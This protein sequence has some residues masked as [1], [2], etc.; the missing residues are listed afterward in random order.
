M[1]NDPLLAGW[2]IWGGLI[3]LP[4]ILSHW[5]WPGG[6]GVCPLCSVSLLSLM[7]SNPDVLYVSTTYEKVG[8][9][10]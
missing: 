2:W 7:G 9:P 8:V 5:E 3:P 4:G 10:P 6:C 1:T